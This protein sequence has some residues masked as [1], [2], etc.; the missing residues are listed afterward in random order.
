MPK[1][2]QTD[3]QSL[4]HETIKLDFAPFHQN[5]ARTENIF[6]FGKLRQ[7]EHIDPYPQ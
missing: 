5:S 7:T 4:P 1:P 3:K 6:R 2:E